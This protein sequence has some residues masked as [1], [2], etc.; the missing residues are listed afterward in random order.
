MLVTTD[1]R[2]P[3]L[4]SSAGVAGDGSSGSE[5][6]IMI[7]MYADMSAKFGGGGLVCGA[8]LQAEGKIDFGSGLGGSCPQNRPFYT[9]GEGGR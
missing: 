1:L 4:S 8:G 3:L 6:P 5:A 7:C 9:Q 2:A